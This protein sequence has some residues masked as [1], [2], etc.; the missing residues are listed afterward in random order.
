MPPT[1]TPKVPPQ[2]PVKGAAFRFRSAGLSF[3][4][5]KTD[6][7]KAPPPVPW[8]VYETRRPSEYEIGQLFRG[9]VG[10]AIIGGRVSGGLEIVDIDAPGL[11]EA[12]MALVEAARPGLLARL[13]RI[14]TPKGGAHVY[15]RCAEIEGNQ[16][17]AMEPFVNDEGKPAQKVLLETRG[18]GGYVL[19]PPSPPECHPAGRAYEHAGGPPLTEVPT[20]TPEERGTLLDAA[21]SFNK[22]PREM[23]SGPPPRLRPAGETGARPGDDFNARASWQEILSPH[24]WTPLRE[25]GP[26]VFW[27]RPGKTDPG[28][29]ATTGHCGDNFYVFSSNAHPFEADTAYTKFAV[30]AILDHGGDYGR[31][32]QALAE[33]GYGVGAADP[34]EM[35]RREREIGEFKSA[36]AVHFVAPDPAGGGEAVPASAPTEA[37]EATAGGDAAPPPKKYKKRDERHA[38]T[39]AR[40]FEGKEFLPARLAKDILAEHRLIAS[41][42]SR[43]EGMGMTLFLYED[44]H[45]SDSGAA[46]IRTKIDSMLG[47]ESKESRIRSVVDLLRERCK[48]D[49][50]AINRKACDLLNVE[51]GMLDWRTG[52]IL[53]HDPSYYSTIRINAKWDP[54]SGSQLVD[55]FL[56]D[57]F[58]PDS[59]ALAEEIMGYLL[60]PSTKMQ[61]SFVLVGEGSNGKTRF[62]DLIRALLGEGNVCNVSLHDV[63][64]GRFCKAELF[65]KL[66][67]VDSETADRMMKSTSQFKAIVGGDRIMGEQKGKDPF[68]FVPFA[69]LLFAAN[70]FPRSHDTTR[71]YFRRLVFVPFEREFKD[72]D[73]D[74]DLGEKLSTPEARARSLVRAVDGL[75]RLSERKA[76]SVP[77]SSKTVMEDYRKECNSAYDFGQS[78]CAPADDSWIKK[79]EMYG[80]YKEW[81]ASGNMKPFSEREFNKILVQSLRFA[82]SRHRTESGFVRVWKGVRWNDRADEELREIQREIDGF[83]SLQNREPRHW[84]DF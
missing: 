47:E 80:T 22:A 48:R 15:Y 44:G 50:R 59:L 79:S 65:G 32:A 36:G 6:G 68:Y 28:C 78:F 3:V 67:N 23:R 35:A 5:I 45:F 43:H 62:F 55:K 75:R 54:S 9:G 2:D 24:G 4:P 21:R 76:F 16:K 40:Y 63:E 72:G 31:A 20:I 25:S 83:G 57:V 7:S 77:D 1:G 51:N 18:E 27:R 46:L 30:L 73:A 70:R 17:L 66:A 12:W 41:P 81:C 34:A 52:E 49:Y 26:T 38:G 60:V 19:A 8:K 82:E 33:H 53:P 71:A 42:V 11:V 84:A 64:E 56:S 61:K 14:R 74:A 69:R 58:P 10:I 13:P 37:P 39:A 29:S